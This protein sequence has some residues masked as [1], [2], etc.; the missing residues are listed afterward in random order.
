MKQKGHNVKNKVICTLAIAAL[1]AAPLAGH[2]LMTNASTISNARNKINNAQN[3]LNDVNNSISNIEKEQKQLQQEISNLDSELVN[4]LVEIDVLKDE[5]ADKNKELKQV[6]KDLVKAQEKEQQQYEDMSKRVQFMYET[7]DNSLLTSILES[8]SLAEVLNR[9]QYYSDV[10]DYDRQLLEEYEQT[11][12]E[13]ASLKDQVEDE[14]SELEEMNDQYQEQ[15][16]DLKTMISKKKSKVS[17]FDT[18]LASAKSLAA[19]YKA[20]ISQQNQVIR[21]EQAKQV[22]AA[23]R[24]AQN[25]NSSSSSNGSSSNSSSSSGSNSSSGGNKNPSYSSDV[26]GSSV[27]DYALS[28]VGNKYVW[29]GTNPNTGA[30]CSGFTQY[31][32]KHFGISLP[33]TSAAQR[34]AG[35]E[36]SY[37]NAQPGDLICYS[38]HVAI[39]MG[40]GKIVHA[41]NSRQGIISG[42]S[43]T[44]R[45]ILSVRRVL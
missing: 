1:A 33:R 45:T 23:Q 4:L 9:I 28:F 19:Q 38:G 11:K 27:V 16:S 6:K 2:G 29:G 14:K 10:Y 5:L 43:A 40:N 41:A 37:K 21:Q 7:G 15:K 31:C 8:K 39:Y 12:K 26:S 13:V 18:Q 35:K 36:V 42:T 25:S 32:F 24:A 44:Y 17:N 20:T 3:N 22:A 30:D 34:S